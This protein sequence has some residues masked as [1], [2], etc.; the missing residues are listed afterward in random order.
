VALV[1]IGTGLFGLA[2]GVYWWA[3]AAH[4]KER[5]NFAFIPTTPTVLTQEGP[6]RVIRHPIYTAYLLA[7]IAG[8][9]ICA[10]PLLLLLTLFMVGL[11]WHA[12]RQEERWFAGSDLAAAYDRYRSRT[13]MFFPSPT[14][15][16][17]R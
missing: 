16:W 5:P 17:R 4:G 6:Y 11:Y 1:V 15:L 7:W 3:R 10:Q 8:P 13:G 2:L 9:V 14:A 12:A